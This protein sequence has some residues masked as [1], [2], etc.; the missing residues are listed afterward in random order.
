M[1]VFVFEYAF[2]FR[3]VD[4]EQLCSLHLDPLLCSTEVRSFM[5]LNGVK[6]ENIWQSNFSH[7]EFLRL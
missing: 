7:S 5:D 4:T 6:P 3:N 1:Y 2:V